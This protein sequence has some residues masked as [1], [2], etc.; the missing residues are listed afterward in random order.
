MLA[1]LV[2]RFPRLDVVACHFGG[3]QQFEEAAEVVVGL[4]VYLDTSWPPGLAEVDPEAVRKV[5]KK[6]GTD[7][8]LFASDWPMADQTAELEAIHALGF[9]DD[10][11]EQILGLNAARLLGLAH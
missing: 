2:R 3:Y 8:I 5:I 1:D 6:H 7:R 10:D 9:P 11:N 4:P